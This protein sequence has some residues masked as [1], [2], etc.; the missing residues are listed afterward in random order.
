MQVDEF[1]QVRNKVCVDVNSDVTEPE[2]Q[3]NGRKIPLRKTMTVTVRDPVA[4]R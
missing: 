1:V 3:E 2:C 4:S